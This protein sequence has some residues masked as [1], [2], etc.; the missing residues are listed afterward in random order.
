MI[1]GKI[2]LI[3]IKEKIDLNIYFSILEH[4]F[5]SFSKP[6]W[7][8]PPFLLLRLFSWH[9]L[10]GHRSNR[11]SWSAE[12]WNLHK[13]FN[14]NL[15]HM[16]WPGFSLLFFFF[17]LFIWLKTSGTNWTWHCYFCSKRRKIYNFTISYVFI[18][19]LWLLFMEKDR[20]GKCII[21]TSHDK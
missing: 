1:W 12:I 3:L 15:W 10:F 9:R 17:L 18:L 21:L 11:V 4:V 2:V 14:R 20:R 19:A 16:I 7:L 8:V 5:L 13:D 6:L